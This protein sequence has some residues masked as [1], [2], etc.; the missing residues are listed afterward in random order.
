MI[1]QYLARIGQ[2]FD[3][4]TTEESLAS[5]HLGH[6]ENIPFENLDIHLG[7]PISSNINHLFEK[8]VLSKRGGYCFEQNGLLAAMLDMVGFKVR[9]VLG[10]T[11]FGASSPRPRGHLLSLVNIG[12]RTWI[13]DVGFGGYGLLEPVP[14]ELD[15]IYQG[16]GE[17]YRVVAAPAGGFELEMRDEEAWKSLYWFDTNPCYSVDIDVVNFYH[18][19]APESFFHQNRVIALARRDG[20]WM[21]TNAELKTIRNSRITISQIRDEAEYIQVLSETFGIDIADNRSRLRAHPAIP[22]VSE[23]FAQALLA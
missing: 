1:E 22:A 6:T 3:I 5:I 2:P 10:R 4:K 13:A 15:S 18:S 21:L 11:T 12:D 14:F 23:P 7:K 20:R 19:H 8:M 9:P 16:G 17:D